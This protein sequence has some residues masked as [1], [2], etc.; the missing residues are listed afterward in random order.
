[1]LSGLCTHSGDKS[2][3]L[4]SGLDSESFVVTSVYNPQSDFRYE[5]NLLS[6]MNVIF[7]YMVIGR[8]RETKFL[9]LC[10]SR[11]IYR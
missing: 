2:V 11:Y 10:A 4:L 7:N 9:L 5:C 3:G 8:L 6:G 1:M